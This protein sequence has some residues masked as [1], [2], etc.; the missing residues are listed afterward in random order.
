MFRL[1]CHV[2]TIG[3]M[4][5]LFRL[6]CLFILKNEVLVH[7]LVQIILLNYKNELHVLIH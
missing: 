7:I 5:C 2:H 3:K 6:S 4:N 1:S